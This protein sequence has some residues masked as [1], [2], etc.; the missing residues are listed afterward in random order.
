MKYLWI[1]ILLTLP[2]FAATCSDSDDGPIDPAYPKD[3]I[4]KPGNAT[5][6]KNSFSDYCMKEKGSIKQSDG[7]WIK[8]YM[9]L[10]TLAIGKDYKCSDYGYEKC[11]T[12]NGLAACVSAGQKTI[13]ALSPKNVTNTTT[14][15]KPKVKLAPQC[16]DK[17][18]QKDRGENCDP[19]GRLCIDADGD[20]GLCEKTCTCKA[21]KKSESVPDKPEQIKPA[22]PAEKPVEP[23]Q[24]QTT[25]PVEAAP[26]APPASETQKPA[27]TLPE[28]ASLFARIWHWL[29]TTFS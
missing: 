9:C 1:M 17:I 18:V 16:G 28:G 3:Y 11:I 13:S 24:T 22:S 6:G 2:V 21:Y 10:N 5:F 12:T 19:P 26:T 4:N 29:S 25:A 27:E 15:P 8:E 7:P 20:A 23:V 14:A